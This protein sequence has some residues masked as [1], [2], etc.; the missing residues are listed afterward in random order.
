MLRISGMT[1]P[2]IKTAPQI[3][4]MLVLQVFQQFVVSTFLHPFKHWG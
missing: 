2:L 4:T 3:K 1:V